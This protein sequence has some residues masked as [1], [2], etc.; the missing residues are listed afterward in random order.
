MSGEKAVGEGKHSLSQELLA[1]RDLTKRTGILY[2][3]QV[4]NLKYWPYVL[5]A[6]SDHQILPDD[7]KRILTFNLKFT[8]KKPKNL[9]ELCYTLERWCWNILGEEWQVKMRD[10]RSGNWLFQ[11]ERGVPWKPPPV[12]GADRELTFEDL[13]REEEDAA[14]DDGS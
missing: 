9:K 11:G 2:E 4:V 5:F 14:R 10:A 8:K 12:E 3:A 6:I 1:L 13:E 7:Q